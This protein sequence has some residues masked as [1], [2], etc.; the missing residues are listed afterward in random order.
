ML[1]ADFCQ[2]CGTRLGSNARFCENCGHAVAAPSPAPT[3]LPEDSS[4]IRGIPAP[5]DQSTCTRN[6]NALIIPG[7]FVA[8]LIVIGLL[9]VVFGALNVSVPKPTPY[10][11]VPPTPAATNP[12]VPATARIENRP[13]ETATRLA[14]APLPTASE[15]LPEPTLSAAPTQS[16]SSPSAA[17]ANTAAITPTP[18]PTLPNGMLFE[19]DFASLDSTEQ[20]GWTVGDDPKWNHAWAPNQFILTT[21]SKGYIALDY[22]QPVFQ[23]AGIQIE[24]QMTGGDYAQYGIV[25]HANDREQNLD[26]MLFGVTTDGSLFLGQ[27]VNGAWVQPLLVPYTP[28]AD[29]RTGSAKNRL[30]ALV[31]HDTLRLYI[32]GKLVDIVT[33]TSVSGS[34]HA[35]IFVYSGNRDLAQAAFSRI[36]ILTTEKANSVWAPLSTLATAP[37][38]ATL[39]AVQPTPIPPTATRRPPTPKPSFTPSPYGGLLFADGFA[40]NYAGWNEGTDAQGQRYFDN[41]QYH[42]FVTASRLTL[43]ANPGNPVQA[44]D[45]VAEARVTALEGPPKMRRGSFFVSRTQAVTI[46]F[47]FHPMEGMP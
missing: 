23:D 6:T 34:G 44:S 24:G 8:G 14:L 25:L 3:T 13:L 29:I 43:I 1:G 33:D 4:S 47:A 21:R 9:L 38:Q 30:S 41:G 32:N 15:T 7:I 42:L 36:S 40:G 31:E 27:L 10:A 12:P 37:P 17:A 19:D 11:V 22:P 2:N 39:V 26:G 35:G 18:A 45:F 16:L 28:S 20:N 46:S 5:A